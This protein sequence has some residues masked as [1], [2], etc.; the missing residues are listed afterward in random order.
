[1]RQLFAPCHFERSLDGSL[2]VA[3]GSSDGNTK[4]AVTDI[5]ATGLGSLKLEERASHLKLNSTLKLVTPDLGVQQDFNM[6]TL[7]LAFS[8]HIAQSI[9]T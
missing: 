5:T 6:Q 3:K 8:L 4:K 7:S 9:K 2:E 1:M